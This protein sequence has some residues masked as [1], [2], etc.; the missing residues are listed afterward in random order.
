MSVSYAF[1][2]MGGYHRKYHYYQG[3]DSRDAAGHKGKYNQRQP[4]EPVAESP[5]T[6]PEAG[7]QQEYKS[8]K[9]QP[10]KHWPWGGASARVKAAPADDNAGRSCGAC[11]GKRLAQ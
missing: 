10:L 1:C 9:K 2:P 11:R 5:R 4:V 3:Y 7:H 8:Y 6:C